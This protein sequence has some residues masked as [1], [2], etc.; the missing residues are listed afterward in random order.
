ML[1]LPG[2]SLQLKGAKYSSAT[3]MYLIVNPP[4]V[5][6][7]HFSMGDL[8]F[9]RSHIEDIGADFTEKYNVFNVYKVFVKGI[10]P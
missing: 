9:Y 3:C 6:L 4:C 1:T 8:P 10:P 2:L 7:M 5:Y